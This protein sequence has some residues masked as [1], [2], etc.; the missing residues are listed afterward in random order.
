MDSPSSGLRPAHSEAPA[1]HYLQQTFES[2]HQLRASDIHFEPFENFYR[3]RL[4]IDGVLQEITPP[5][6]EFREHIASR[7]KV[8][9]HLD[10]AEKRLPQDGRMSIGLHNAQKL[11]LRISTL[12]TLF[13]EKLVVRTLTNDPPNWTDLGCSSAPADHKITCA[14]SIFERKSTWLLYQLSNLA[15]PLNQQACPQCNFVATS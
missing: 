13:G 3:V 15:Q 4:R 7:I 2:A 12:P 6:F 11:H 8:L 5:P 14:L 10:I 1:V 9:A